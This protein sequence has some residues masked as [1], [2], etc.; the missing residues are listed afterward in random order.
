MDKQKTDALFERFAMFQHATDLRSP[1]AFGFEC[2]D[3]WYQLIL[4]L[5]EEIEKI[6]LADGFMVVQVKE[7]FGGLRFYTSFVT[8]ELEK[9]IRKA[10]D[11]SF[12]ICEVCG[13]DG[14][15]SH[16]GTWARTL[17]RVCRVRDGYTRNKKAEA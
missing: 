17:C 7:K 14:E 5:C 11:A 12:T 9:L 16:L 6:K 13:N 3:G 10:E 15:P 2:G 4:N 8:G 1:M